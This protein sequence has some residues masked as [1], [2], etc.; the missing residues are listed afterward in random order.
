MKFT[1]NPHAKYAIWAKES[2]VH[3]LPKA[4]GL[5]FFG[6]KKFDSYEE[7]N[8]WKREYLDQI[9]RNGGVTWTR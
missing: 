1:D 8:A 5:P 3:P 7:F 2:K 6:S 4:V 9:A